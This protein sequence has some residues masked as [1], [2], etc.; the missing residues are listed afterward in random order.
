MVASE[1]KKPKP[2]Q[3]VLPPSITADDM[4]GAHSIQNSVHSATTYKPNHASDVRATYTA[5]ITTF[6]PKGTPQAMSVA[7]VN[8]PVNALISTYHPQQFIQTTQR[9]PVEQSLNDIGTKYIENNKFSSHYNAKA[10][11]FS[12]T[13]IAPMRPNVKELLATIGLRPDS[14]QLTPSTTTERPVTAIKIRKATTTTSTTTTTEQPSTT[15]ETN[16]DPELKELLASFG[17]LTNEQAPPYATFDTY[18]EEFQPIVPSSLRD[19]TLHVNDFKPLPASLLPEKIEKIESIEEFDDNIEDEKPPIRSD[20]FSSFKPLPIPEDVSPPTDS[21]LEE[22]LK[23]FGLLD[24]LRDS[25]SLPN[26]HD[27]LPVKKEIQDRV[28]DVPEENVEFLSPDLI[29][30]LDDMG[31][32]KP[33]QVK[34]TSVKNDDVMDDIATTPQP[35][36][37]DYEK[38][39]Y[40]LDTIKELDKLNE[41]LTETEHNTLNL[42]NFNLSDEFSAQGPDPVD[43]YYKSTRKNEIKRRQ[44]NEADAPTDDA[45]TENTLKS[46]ESSSTT[47]IENDKDSTTATFSS[48]SDSSTTENDENSSSSSSSSSTTESTTTTTTEESRNGNIKDLA[49]SFGGESGLDTVADESLPPPKPNGFYFFADWNSF[50]EVGEDPDKVVVRFDP[51]VGDPRRFI[52][53]KIP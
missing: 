3:I 50:L 31:L 2:Q 48:T 33:K 23:N 1:I 29:Q 38:L 41:N 47:T 34:S 19:E 39:H 26:H 20:D 51:K 21:E 12:P 25:K 35:N 15:E 36:E 49:D 6:H 13:S 17:L 7:H 53:V 52:P 18:Q 32:A 11:P 24:N 30:V 45:K 28:L 16:I 10:T 46:T 14:T 42:R 5:P 37:E 4:T 40:L 9:S 22:L 27:E 8:I 44:S 43:V